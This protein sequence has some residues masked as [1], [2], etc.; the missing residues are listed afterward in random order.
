MS[1]SPFAA[2]IAPNTTAMDPQGQF[3]YVENCGMVCANLPVPPESFS[4]DG[5]SAYS[6]NN[7]SGALTAVP[8]SPF[9]FAVQWEN[10]LAL[11]P[12]GHF[13]YEASG[14][15]GVNVLNVDRGSGALVESSGLGTPWPASVAVDPL[16]QFVYIPGI[17]NLP[18]QSFPAI[19]GYAI[20]P[21]NGNLTPVAGSP[22]TVAAQTSPT[23]IAIA[24]PQQ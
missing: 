3:L 12:S 23:S 19:A 21:T 20:N 15:G 5:I 8:G 4:G 22:F 13:A 24:I 7:V 9:Q 1:G 11:D 2:G 16:G 17:V 10:G 6:I 18:N 14:R